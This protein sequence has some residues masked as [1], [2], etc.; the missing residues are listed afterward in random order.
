MDRYFYSVELANNGEKI[1]HLSGNVYFND[2]DT[3]EKQYRLAEWTYYYISIRATKGLIEKDMF[4]EHINEDVNYLTDITEQEAVEI[5]NTYWNGEA[6]E[7]LHI[8]DVNEDTP[9]GDYWFE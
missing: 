5:C 8:N 3:G 1:I 6:G 7:Y 9:C 2:T 4:Y